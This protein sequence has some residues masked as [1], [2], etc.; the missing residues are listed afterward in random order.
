MLCKKARTIDKQDVTEH[1]A[2]GNAQNG[3]RHVGSHQSKQYGNG[4]TKYRQ[5]SKETHQRSA[6]AHEALGTVH[7]LLAD[8][9]VSLKPLC[10]SHSAHTIVEHTARHVAD[11][12]IYNQLH[13][14]ETC[15]Q[16]CKHYRL[17]AE[18]EHTSSKECR[19][20]QTPVAVSYQ[21]VSEGVHRP[22][23]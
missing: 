2:D 23:K 20:E 9:Q 13:R 14:V 15:R 18:R 12:A 22:K 6:V 8:V 1:F 21:K 11:A 17:A 4:T 16:E 10:L 19:K 3:Q 5:E 7:V